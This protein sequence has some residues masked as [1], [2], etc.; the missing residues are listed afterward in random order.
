VETQQVELSGVD[1][2]RDD[3]G[4]GEAA[5]RWFVLGLKTGWSIASDADAVAREFPQEALV[6]R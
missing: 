6:A 4:S 3:A 1:V 2:E 5:D